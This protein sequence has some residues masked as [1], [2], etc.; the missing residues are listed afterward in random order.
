[1]NAHDL[2]A[3]LNCFHD[4]YR[5]EHPVHPGRGF[6]GRDQVRTNWSTI[7]A[8]IP[9][10]AAELR[11]HCEGTARSGPSAV[12]PERARMEAPSKWRA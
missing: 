8:G 4:D 3:F 12:R 11:S 1:M 7:F 5:S 6:G 9:D 10:F 2:E